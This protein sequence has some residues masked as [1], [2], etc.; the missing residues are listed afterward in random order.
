[1]ANLQS[2]HSLIFGDARDHAHHTLYNRAYFMGLIF[3]DSSLSVKFGPLKNFPIYHYLI[4][5]L[6]N[7]KFYTREKRVPGTGIP[8]SLGTGTFPHSI[9]FP[10]LAPIKFMFLQC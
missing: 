10:P 1:M 4:P 9:P 2:I 7:I 3:A 6:P 5:E 8:L